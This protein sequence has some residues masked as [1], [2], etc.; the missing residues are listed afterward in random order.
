MLLSVFSNYQASNYGQK[1]GK[2]HNVLHAYHCDEFW[3]CKIKLTVPSTET[4]LEQHSKI[5]I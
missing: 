4:K 1:C 3:Q 5:V 2:G